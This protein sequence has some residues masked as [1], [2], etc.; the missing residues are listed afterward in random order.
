MK[1]TRFILLFTLIL[2]SVSPAAAQTKEHMLSVMEQASGEPVVGAAVSYADDLGKMRHAVTDIDGRARLKVM[3]G[4]KYRYEISFVGLKSLKGSFNGSKPPRRLY[5]KEDN[6]LID[7]VVVKGSHAARPVKLTPV[8]TQVISAS[9]MVNSGYGDVKKVLMQETPGLNIQKV[10]FGNEISLQGLDARHVVFLM[11]GERMTGDMAGNL[12]YERFNLHAIDKIEIVKGATSTL[13]GS[14]A[15]GAVINMITKRPTQRFSIT[16]GGRWGQMNERNYSS[17]SPH[18]FLYMYEKHVDR[19]NLQWWTSAGLKFWKIASQTDVWY[20]QSDAFYLYQKGLDEK[21]YTRQANPF[22]KED[23]RMV[24]KLP[25]APMGVEGG[26]HLTVSQKLFF[27]PFKGLDL[28]VYGKGFWINQFDLVPDLLFSQSRDYTWGGKI[29]WRFRDWFRIDATVNSDYYYNYKRDERRDERSKVYNSHL[30]QPKLM[31]SS[32]FFH[33]HNLKFGVE[34]YNDDLTSNRFSGVGD[35]RELTRGLTETEFLFQDEWKINEKWMT[36]L[37]VRTNFS[38]VFGFMWMPT[39]ATK[40]SPSKLW[41]FRATYSKGYRSPSI[42]ELFFNWDNMGM[43]MIV[44][45]EFLKP[46]KNHY[47]SLGAEFDNDVCFVNADVYLNHYKNKIEGVWSIYD[48]QYNFEYENLRSQ[49]LVGTEILAKLKAAR[50]LI[51]S[52]SYAYVNISKTDGRAISTTSPH[53]ATGGV[54]Y[55]FSKKG[56]RLTAGFNASYMGRKRYDVQ[57]RLQMDGMS[58]DAYFRCSLPSYILCNMNVTQTFYDSLKLTVGVD[59]VFNYKPHTLGSGLT[60]F[61]I[62]ATAGTR[63]FAQLQLT[64]DSAMKW[65]RRK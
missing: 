57:D 40:F 6:R 33:G 27:K 7:E 49:N 20:S 51:L 16:A 61:N 47:F 18:D 30:F 24:S 14:R 25:R 2:T 53:S 42:K 26:E 28:E 38:D 12:D 34:H 17:P 15:S 58:R 48:L 13:Y 29:S 3:S 21:V 59:N 65:L 44:G 31:V 55:S 36:T 46:E 50:G 60:A 56:Y 35:R 5:M 54:E 1:L 37:G 8:T 32:D 62:P 52:A 23:V 41:H 39:A 43:F 45:N 11:D 19:P 63:V 22:L 9:E 4:R 64:V 10:G